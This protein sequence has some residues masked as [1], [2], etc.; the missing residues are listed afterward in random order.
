MSRALF[1]KHLRP[2]RL[3]VWESVGTYIPW[4]V[5][6][7]ERTSWFLPFT[8][9]VCHLSTDCVPQDVSSPLRTF[10]DFPISALPLS[11]GLLGSQMGTITHS[12]FLW[13]SGTG[14]GSQA[15]TRSS[16][17]DWTVWLA[18]WTTLSSLIILV[19]DTIPSTSLPTRINFGCFNRLFFSEGFISSPLGQKNQLYFMK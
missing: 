16:F 10:D 2:F 1:P 19:I 7:D 15:C 6:G 5:N 4:S 11:I 13:V 17:A 18:R 3:C 8:V 9:L 14:L 12:F